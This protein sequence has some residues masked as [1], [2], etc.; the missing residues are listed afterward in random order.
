MRIL[1]CT[2]FYHDLGGAYAAALDTEWLLR[3]HGHSVIPFA[4]RHPANRPTPF[5]ADFVRYEPLRTWWRQRRYLRTARVVGRVV[6]SAEAFHRLRRLL[7]REKPDLV[8]VHNFAYHLSPSVFA[9]ASSAGVRVVHTLHDYKLIC[10]QLS[11]SRHGDCCRACRGGRFF[12]CV[13]H[14]CLENSAAM[15]AVAA[16][17]NYLLAGTKVV[18][19][20]VGAYLCPSRFLQQLMAAS[21]WPAERLLHLP[22]FVRPSFVRPCSGGG[23]TPS[24]DPH[25]PFLFAGRLTKEKG[26]DTLLEAA[27][28]APECNVLVAGDGPLR[29]S[30]EP[31]ASGNVRFLGAVPRER[32]PAL[33][34]RALAV[35][36]PSRWYE[37]CSLTVL[38]AFAAGRAVLAA[39][40]GGLPEQVRPDQTGILVPPGH[41]DALAAAM[42]RLRAHPDLA[43]EWGE[44]A[45]RA[46][47]TTWSPEVHYSRL[48]EI[49]R[50]Q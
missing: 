48:L 36:V 10:P 34:R 22:N 45:R 17:Q 26:V 42:L 20:S 25:G 29:R 12:N 41:P 31:R 18:R 49:Y 35:V 28:R 7:N 43:R 5:A 27:R 24:P 44:N 21:G 30:W 46:A 1:L 33:Y 39:N 38:E 8:H 16:G 14:R 50:S 15:S 23:P 40:I 3:A 13:R 9:A 47:C 11:L 6:W 2:E 32:M 37:N 4:A 19:R